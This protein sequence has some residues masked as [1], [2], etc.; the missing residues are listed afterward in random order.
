MA[1][2]Q[3]RTAI[4]GCGDYLSSNIKMQNWDW[5]EISGFFWEEGDFGTRF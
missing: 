3:K 2:Y 5:G 1:S 4:M